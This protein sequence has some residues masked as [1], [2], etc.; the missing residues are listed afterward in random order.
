MFEIDNTMEYIE[1]VLL[2]NG[3]EEISALRQ[4]Q[5]TFKNKKC[6]IDINIQYPEEKRNFDISYRDKSGAI[7]ICSSDNLN[8]YFLFGFLSA[9][10]LVDRNFK[11]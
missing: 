4:Y 7:C 9:H 10:D 1:P 3:F 11:L 6:Q 2:G 8:L 5:R